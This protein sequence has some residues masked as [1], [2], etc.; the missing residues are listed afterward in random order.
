MLA[1]LP[2]RGRG[3]AGL[4]WQAQVQGMSCQAWVSRMGRGQAG[5]GWQ[6]QVQGMRNVG[7]RWWWGGE[8]EG[9]KASWARTTSRAQGWGLAKGV[10]VEDSLAIH[11]YLPR[12]LITNCLQGLGFV[13]DAELT[14]G[15]RI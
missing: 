7:A 8:Q 11:P 4:G 13:E 1:L 12:V 14:Q 2:V 15:L 6:A 9:E 10:R 3:Q 5:L